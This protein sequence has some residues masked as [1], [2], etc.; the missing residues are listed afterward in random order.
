MGE[1]S[2]MPD[3]PEGSE[4]ENEPDEVV[5]RTTAR[6]V[7]QPVSE[8]AGRFL[9]RGVAKAKAAMRSPEARESA[10][11]KAKAALT[12]PETRESGKKVAAAAA[13]K[14]FARVKGPAG[15]LISNKD[16][17][18]N[19]A[20]RGEGMKGKLDP[21]SPLGKAGEDL[22][23]L[24]RLIRA[25]ATGEYRDVSL[26]SMG[27]IVAAV[28]YVVSPLDL[29]PEF[30]PGIGGLDDLT[31]LGLA[32]KG[33]RKELDEFLAWEARHTGPQPPPPAALPPA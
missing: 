29:I 13:T 3:L 30:I 22:G 19:L 2:G 7:D 24:L 12:S 31:V 27:L 4:P 21:N 32:L 28:A 20:S 23:T 6:P 1:N 26:E 18:L 16:K 17:L 5:A 10:V 11:A 9:G 14:Y 15:K 33:V 8:R 25:Y